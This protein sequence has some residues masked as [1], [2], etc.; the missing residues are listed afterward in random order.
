MKQKRNWRGIIRCTRYIALLVR[1][2][3]VTRSCVFSCSLGL[4]LILGQSHLSALRSKLNK[5]S[6]DTQRIHLACCNYLTVLDLVVLLRPGNERCYSYGDFPD[7]ISTSF[8]QGYERCP[9]RFAC[10]L[11]CVFVLAEC[12]NFLRSLELYD[13]LTSAFSPS[14][15]RAF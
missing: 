4:D 1:V 13:Q 2:L 10:R 8:Q 11:P 9:L 15:Y 6:I 3:L 5:V 7:S 14:L 12:R